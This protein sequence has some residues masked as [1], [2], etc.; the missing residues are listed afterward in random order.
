MWNNYKSNYMK[1]TTPEKM[2]LGKKFDEK[3]G[4][5]YRLEIKVW[6]SFK[7]FS[8]KREQYDFISSKTNWETREVQ[9]MIDSII[10]QELYV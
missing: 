3:K 1:M 9:E 5:I 8:I 6:K 7:N 10:N 4:L 2:V